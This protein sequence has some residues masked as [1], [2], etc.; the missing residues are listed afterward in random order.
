VGINDLE[1]SK[2]AGV[3]YGYIDAK[4][5]AVTL[6]LGKQNSALDASISTW[7]KSNSEIAAAAEK[8]K[9]LT[10]FQQQHIPITGELLGQI[11][12]LAAGYGNLAKRADEA[13]QA[14]QQIIG[15]MDGVRD[16]AKGALSTFLN[17]VEQ[18]KK[19]SQ[20]LKDVEKSLL[21]KIQSS[22]E[23]SLI[24]GIFG[25][26]GVPGGGMIGN[27]LGG[28]F[29]SL[30]GGAFGGNNFAGQS[31]G[32]I[33]PFQQTSLFSSIG[34]FFGFAD[35]GVMTSGGPL[36]LHRYANGGV[37]NTPQV[38]MFG[39]GRGPEAYVPLPDGRSIP[40]NVKGAPSP[41]NANGATAP[42]ITINNN[43]AGVT[44]TPEIT[45]G[46]MIFHID[47]RI[48]ANNKRLSEADR[49]SP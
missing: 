23:D 10:E 7:G 20:T 46:E 47:N 28:L 4:L 44:V 15:A 27:Q 31:A 30:F 14:Q 9:L 21:T 25:K 38:A 41:A 29:G 49:R 32:A 45:R 33:G 22:A 43:A 16:A 42:K 26:S 3:D 18:R 48:A 17:D 24:S 8:E 34:S 5:N 37:A 12:Q 39:E 19:A 1:K 35:G 13:K 36:P 40:V 11:D 2:L 6:D